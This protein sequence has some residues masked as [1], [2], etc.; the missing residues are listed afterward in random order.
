MR[1]A[2]SQCDDHIESAYS[3]H[4]D[5]HPLLGMKCNDQ[6]YIDPMLP[7]GLRSAPKIF[8]ALADAAVERLP[9]LK[10][11]L[12]GIRRCKVLGGGGRG[13]GGGGGETTK[14]MSPNNYLAPCC[15][16]SKLR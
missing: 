9:V 11:V 16:V 12:G 2:R 1:V 8:N 15:G 3:V 14:D 5:D 10:R 4:P 6:F 13:G 7:L